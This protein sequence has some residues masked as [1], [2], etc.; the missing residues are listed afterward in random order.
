MKASSRR[1]DSLIPLSREH[2]YALLLC[3]RI[4]RGLIEHGADSAWLQT[5]ANHAISFFDEE[6][7]VHFQAEEE[8]LFPAM[9]EL[10]GAPP[11]IDQLLAEHSAIRLLI[12]EL[13]DIDAVSIASRIKEFADSL[14]A[15][16]RKEERELFP[17]YQDQA[18][19]ETIARVQ[20]AIFSRIGSAAKPR[21]PEL[22]E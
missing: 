5:K 7:T 22:L 4:H 13:R 12:N 9:R 21:R 18:S 20:R 11:I 15:H 8:V 16:I 1:D 19:P 3:L 6:L 2:Q 14:E 10:S 17:I